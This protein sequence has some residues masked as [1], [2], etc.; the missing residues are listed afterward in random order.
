[1]NAS[2][3]AGSAPMAA[4]RLARVSGRI[5]D[6]T[7][8]YRAKTDPTELLGQGRAGRRLAGPARPGSA[9]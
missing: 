6:T 9:A 3:R 5:G 4:G 2:R 8:P 7:G 1:M